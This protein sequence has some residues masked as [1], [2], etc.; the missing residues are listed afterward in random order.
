M[1]GTLASP[2]AQRAWRLFANAVAIFTL[3]RA[4]LAL[5]RKGIRGLVKPFVNMLT[6]NCE[7][8]HV[9]RVPIALRRSCA[10]ALN[11]WRAGAPSYSEQDAPGWI[12][13]CAACL[14]NRVPDF[15]MP[16]GRV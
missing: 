8:M 7:R 15:T 16:A 1:A 11:K 2:K 5:R 9:C 6:D 13:W 3:L 14:P 12:R 10:V 4:A